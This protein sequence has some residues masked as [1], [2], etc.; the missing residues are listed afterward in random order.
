[1]QI[2]AIS[3][4]ACDVYLDFVND[5]RR[6]PGA[7]NE[8]CGLTP[9]NL[10]HGYGNWGV[11]SNTGRIRDSDQFHG[12][13]PGKQNSR[14]RHWQSCTS[15]H[16]PPTCEHYNDDNCTKQKANA[17]DDRVYAKGTFRRWH[18]SCRDRF[19]GGVHVVRSVYMSV[20]ELDSPDPDDFI[21][22]IGYGT[23]TIPVTCNALWTCTGDSG[24]KQP[25]YGNREV[26]AKVKIKLRT[27]RWSR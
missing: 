4:E 5:D 7:V 20:Y 17:D 14:Q 9:H 27:K 12:W 19:S 16:P 3:D 18:M 8:E 10:D 21:T 15:E 13:K 6:V 26:T 1:M 11:E 2:E 25:T 23:I 22:T 24:W